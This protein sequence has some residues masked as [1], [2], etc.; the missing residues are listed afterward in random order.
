M[1]WQKAVGKFPF[2]LI[3]ASVNNR[4]L[5]ISNDNLKT[6][7]YKTEILVPQLS[8]RWGFCLQRLNAV[9]HGV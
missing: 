7:L 3:D 5:G 6:A 1:Q 2:G 9:F 4:F 8:N